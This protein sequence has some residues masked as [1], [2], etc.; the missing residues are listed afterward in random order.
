MKTYHALQLLTGFTKGVNNLNVTLIIIHNALKN[1]KI[2]LKPVQSDSKIILLQEIYRLSVNGKCFHTC[3]IL[4]CTKQDVVQP[5]T[6]GIEEIRLE[7]RKSR[8]FS[9]APSLS[10]FVHSAESEKDN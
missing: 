6:D 2:L 8:Q 3:W 7:R 5:E 9:F 1:W 10:V 4:D